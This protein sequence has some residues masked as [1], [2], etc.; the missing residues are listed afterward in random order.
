M[1]V[2]AGKHRGRVLAE[3]QGDRVR[4]TPDRVKE[5]LFQIL[6]E[7]LTDARV[8]DLFCGSGA[9]GIESLSRGARE[10]V[11]NDESRESLAILRK[12]LALVKES[13]VIYQ[14]D[15]RSCL[16]RAEGQF[17]LIFSDP[18]YKEDY[19]TEICAL[20][21]NGRLL[22]EGGLLVHES[23]REERAPEGWTVVDRRKYGRTSVSMLALCE[24]GGEI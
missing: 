14:L 9:L 10:V 3:F 12:N 20:I 11:F 1:R 15:Y 22:C 4:P 16:K 7:R 18:P 5:S 23:E 17:D 19:L 24:D 6:G 21:E 8:L 13:G 2:I